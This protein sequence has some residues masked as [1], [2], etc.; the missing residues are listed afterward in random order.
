VPSGL[1]RLI[2]W[3]YQRGVWQYDVIVCLILLFIFASPREWFNDQPRVPN[4]AQITS[5]NGESA[6]WIDT[7]L[8]TSIPEN[9]RLSEITKI[10]TART[11]KQHTMMR[12]EP[13]YDAE[14]EL[15][16]YMAFSK[17]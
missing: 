6:F 16:G 12:I 2:L 13:I 4:A 14:H 7:E 10:L 5:H 11:R 15:Q 1:R 17:P 8:V 3:D 9:Q